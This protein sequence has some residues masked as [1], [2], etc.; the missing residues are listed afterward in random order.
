MIVSDFMNVFRISMISMISSKVI[1]GFL[2]R[3]MM[4]LMVS[5]GICLVVRI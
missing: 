5:C 4:L 2:D 3:L 1:I